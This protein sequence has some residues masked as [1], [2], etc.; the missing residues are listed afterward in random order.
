MATASDPGKIWFWIRLVQITLCTFVIETQ[1]VS[2][3]ASPYVPE[4]VNSSAFNYSW[5]T[6]NHTISSTYYFYLFKEF[7]I[8]KIILSNNVL[9]RWCFNE[10]IN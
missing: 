6:N 8:A 5:A 2:W 10:C 3:L 1:N 9:L 4:I 7:V